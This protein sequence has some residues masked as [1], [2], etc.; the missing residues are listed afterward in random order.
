MRKW[1]MIR[2]RGRKEGAGKE[3]IEKVGYDKKKRAEGGSGK[4][5]E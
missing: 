3:R 2:R 1:G 5:K 4:R